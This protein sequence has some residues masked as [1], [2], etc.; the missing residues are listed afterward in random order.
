MKLSTFCKDISG[1]RFHRLTAIEP[2]GKDAHGRVIWK[3]KCDCGE[4][5]EVST[6]SL[7]TGNTKSC[8]CL[9]V[10]KFRRMIT[11]HGYSDTRTYG[12]WQDIKKRCFDVNEAEFNRYGGRGI[13][14]C[15]EWANDFTAFLHDMGECPKGMT[16]D[17]ID[18]DG[19][20]EPSNCRWADGFT[21]GNNKSNNINIEIDGVT[22]TM[23]Q[24]C[25][26]YG[27]SQQTAH[28]RIS[29][30]HWNPIDAVTKPPRKQ[31]KVRA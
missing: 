19:N 8:G 11:K 2:V 12:I 13:T 14:M 16:I 5:V 23:T 4:F 29:T 7:T 30:L 15:K 3:C 9:K 17:R 31:K 27:I 24:W 18:N 25:R 22:K 21:Q 26:V 10:D 20:Y 1:Q 28:S 6:H